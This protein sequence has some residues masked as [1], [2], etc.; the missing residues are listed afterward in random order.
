MGAWG[1]GPFENDDALDAIAEISAG[2]FSLDLLR[3]A[4]AGD[5]LEAPE[6]AVAL[7][8]LE[9]ALAARGVSDPA[10]ELDEVDIRL[11]AQQLDQND[12]EL[13][14]DA[15]QRVLNS[16]ASELYE[17]WEEAEPEEF[18]AWKRQAAQSIS[19]LGD[20]IGD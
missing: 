14:L 3:D 12:Y 17:L 18:E 11:V 1:T 2:T 9:V 6:G 19:A 13:I 15:A 10:A 20:A 8:V 7:A 5:Y 4:I 16:V